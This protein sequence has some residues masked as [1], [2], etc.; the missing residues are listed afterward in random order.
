[1][2]SRLNPEYHICSTYTNEFTFLCVFYNAAISY[3]EY[4]FAFTAG[5]KKQIL[6]LSKVPVN[7]KFSLLFHNI[8]QYIKYQFKTDTNFHV[9]MHSCLRYC[10]L[11]DC[12][13]CKLYIPLS[14]PMQIM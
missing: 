10:Y 7:Q 5:A 2:Q 13:E 1:M 4:Y 3:I 8:E 9:C 14:V 12:N 6:N 11:L